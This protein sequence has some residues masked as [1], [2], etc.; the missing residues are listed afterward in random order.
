[1]NF[2]KIIG[3]LATVAGT[4]HPGIGAAIGLVNRFVDP[5]HQLP[6]S[7]TGQEAMA[8]YDSLPPSQRIL[9]NQE[10]DEFAHLLGIEKEHTAQWV[11]MNQAD[12]S[13]SATR[14]RVVLIFAWLMCFILAAFCSFLFVALVREGAEGVAEVGQL[15]PLLAAAT[16]LPTT[17]ILSYFNHRGKEKRTRYAVMN[18]HEPSAISGVLGAVLGAIRK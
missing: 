15:W 10:A 14:P 16:S 7:A 8:A 5:E 1:M 18:G 17:V 2:K 11:A 13:G 3:G 12:S 4:I 6:A 9:V